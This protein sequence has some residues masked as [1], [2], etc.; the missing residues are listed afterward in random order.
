M[1]S[2]MKLDR[3]SAITAEQKGTKPL[4]NDTKAT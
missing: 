3:K 4:K 1:Q 2:S